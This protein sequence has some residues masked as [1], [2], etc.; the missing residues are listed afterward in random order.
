MIFLLLPS[1]Q[2]QRGSITEGT[3][4]CNAL[5]GRLAKFDKPCYNGSAY[6]GVA[7]W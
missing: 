6:G 2:L 3:L 5:A 1:S 4:A 7:K